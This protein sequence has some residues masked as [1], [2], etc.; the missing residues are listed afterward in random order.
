[1]PRKKKQTKIELTSIQTDEV[2]EYER[3]FDRAKATH[4]NRTS[5]HNIYSKISHMKNLYDDK[6]AIISEGSVQALKR[7]VIAQTLQRVPDGEL[8]TQFDKNS[9]EHVLTEFLFKNKVITSEFAGKDMY[10]NLR[11][12]F[13]SAF[14]YGFACVRTGFEKDGFGDV[15]ISWKN[16]PYN[17][18][19]PEPDCDYIEEADWYIIEEM[20]SISAIEG[21][22]DENDKL[23]DS[24]WNEK[25]LRFLRQDKV[26]DGEEYGQGNRLQDDMKGVTKK[27]S[28]CLRTLYRKGDSEFVTYA[29][30]FKIEIRRVKNYDPRKDVPV[31]FLILQPDCEFPLGVSSVMPLL[32]QQQFADAFMSCAYNQ[33]LL[34]TNPPMKVFGDMTQNDL[35]MAPKVVIDMGTNPNNYIEPLKVETNTLMQYGSILE[36]VSASMSRNLNISDQ[37]IA[38]DAHVSGWSKTN[39][40]VQAQ[41]Q[42]K[43]I[44]INIYQKSVETF[45]SEWANHAMRSYLSAMNGVKMITVDEETRRKIWDIEEASQEDPTADFKSIVVGNQV[46]V[47]FSTLSYDMLDFQVRTGSLIQSRQD[48][49]RKNIQEMLVPVSQ[50]IGALSENN[51]P[52]FEDN[53]ML[54]VQRLLELSDVDFAA[55]AGG[56]I[57]NK[58]M[59]EAIKAAYQ[60]I[61]DQNKAIGQLQQVMMQGLPQQGTQP[62]EAPTAGAGAMEQAAMQG[63]PQPQPAPAEEQAMAQ[64]HTAQGQPMEQS[65]AEGSSQLPPEVMQRLLEQQQAQANSGAEGQEQPQQ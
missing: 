11:R 57:N 12:T 53:I 17:L 65:P 44:T 64:E 9:I 20:M 50:M 43:T 27:E 25:S 36:N 48:V 31:H 34:A 58:L 4:L 5:E 8:I 15:R 6:D 21:L 56:Q 13:S 3:M 29:P 19:F 28:I 59:V 35:Y 30:K 26:Y 40:G 49:Q 41:E 55:N 10:K 22:F 38:S 47:D 16:I 39:E 61:I 45:F 46:Q 42:D 18:V 37:T 32:S 52:A 60:Q 1:M 23:V 33:L 63:Q 2:E 7:K 51:R 24:T 54:M 62:Q 14:D